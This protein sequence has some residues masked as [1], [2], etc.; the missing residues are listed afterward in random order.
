VPLIEFPPKTP[1]PS[2]EHRWNRAAV[3]WRLRE[4][5]FTSTYGHLQVLYYV[6]RWIEVRAELAFGT[7]RSTF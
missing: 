2:R 7:A 3:A 6:R 5:R 1:G 4:G